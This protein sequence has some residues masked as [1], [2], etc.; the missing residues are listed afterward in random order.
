MVGCGFAWREAPYDERMAFLDKMTQAGIEYRTDLL[1]QGTAISEEACRTGYNLLDPD[2]P[3]DDTPRFQTDKWKD[4][5][6]EAYIKGCLTG[7]A[8]PK[9]EP[10]WSDVVP[11]VPHGSTPSSTPPATSSS[12]P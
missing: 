2:K 8:R 3:Y 11:V 12:G 6:E 7:Q 4:Q 10:S 9:P 1:D 5:I